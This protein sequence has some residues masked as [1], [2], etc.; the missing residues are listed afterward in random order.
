MR[1]QALISA[2]L[3]MISALPASAQR[4]SADL[5][6]SVAEDV[7]TRAALERGASVA[8]A[9]GSSPEADAAVETMQRGWRLDLADTAKMLAERGVPAD[10]VQ[11]IVSRFDLDAVTP[12]LA[13]DAERKAFCTV[14]GDGWM[15][16]QLLRHLIPQFEI[17]RTLD[18]R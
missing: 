4:P 15:R 2:L 1:Y 12:R 16:Y 14:V 5:V 11:A 13:S 18:R 8:C 6:A 7:L 3:V 17:R 9:R 10:T